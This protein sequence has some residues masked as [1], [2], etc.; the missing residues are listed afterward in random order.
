LLGDENFG[1]FPARIDFSVNRFG[2]EFDGFAILVVLRSEFCLVRKDRPGDRVEH[3]ASE[4]FYEPL[5]RGSLHR[6]PRNE[7]SQPRDDRHH[8]DAR[9]DGAEGLRVRRDVR[10]EEGVDLRQ[11]ERI[12]RSGRPG[13]Q[14]ADSSGKDRRGGDENEYSEHGKPFG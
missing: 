10:R 8:R 14:R 5:H 3:R 13:D 9:Y 2:R 1:G 6:Q 12:R 4:Q 11:I 7:G